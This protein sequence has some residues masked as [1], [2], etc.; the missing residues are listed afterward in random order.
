MFTQ[1]W[2]DFIDTF[3]SKEEISFSQRPAL[4]LSL[5]FAEQELLYVRQCDTGVRPLPMPKEY[6]S[7]VRF[8]SL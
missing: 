4:W 8:T 1:E 3:L 7:H 6:P 2:L 5:V